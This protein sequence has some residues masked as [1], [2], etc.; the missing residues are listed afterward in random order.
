MSEASSGVATLARI[1][2][3]PAHPWLHR[4]ATHARGA[5]AA[6]QPEQHRRFSNVADAATPLD[7][8]ASS[9]KWQR[10]ILDAVEEGVAMIVGQ[11][12]GRALRWG[13]FAVKGG[14]TTACR[15]QNRGSMIV[16][17]RRHYCAVENFVHVG[18]QLWKSSSFFPFAAVAFN[19]G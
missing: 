6:S 9:V 13:G 5:C 15:M 3:A 8:R 12:D 10:G 17:K 7:R 19:T 11:G 16:I 14:V 4:C 1:R 18:E 2:D